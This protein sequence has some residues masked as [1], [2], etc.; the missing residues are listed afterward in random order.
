MYSA[1]FELK[2]RP[3]RH[4]FVVQECESLHVTDVLPYLTG[5]HRD[6]ISSWN[7][8]SHP[9]L[10]LVP[11][12]GGP[13]RR[14]WWLCPRCGRMCENLYVPP[15]SRPDDWRCRLCWS[16][17]YA[18]QR[19]GERHPLRKK[20]THRRKTTLRKKVLRQSR[21]EERLQARQAREDREWAAAFDGDDMDLDDH[22]IEMARRRLNDLLEQ[23]GTVAGPRIPRRAGSAPT[24]D[25]PMADFPTTAKAVR[26]EARRFLVQH[27]L[28]PA[29]AQ[30]QPR[31]AVAPKPERG[32]PR[33]RLSRAEIE[34][35]NRAAA[36]DEEDDQPS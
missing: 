35:L 20:L 30:S 22:A 21:R 1:G 5:Y 27:G 11:W 8:P 13:F 12:R 34:R 32:V 25:P 2:K 36:E 4:D 17:I 28:M 9:S 15:D 7:P 26:R 24:A 29:E 19:Y 6:L 33:L 16:L 18:S 14:W 3:K 10:T 23:R 31:R